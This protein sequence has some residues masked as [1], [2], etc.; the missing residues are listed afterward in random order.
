MKFDMIIIKAV[1]LSILSEVA[2]ISIILLTI[3]I[4]FCIMTFLP[5]GII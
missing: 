2:I 5:T 1:L 3:V 4:L